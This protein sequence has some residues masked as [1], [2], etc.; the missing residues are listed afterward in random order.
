MGYS[1]HKDIISLEQR[2]NLKKN[3]KNFGLKAI[4][5]I[6]QFGWL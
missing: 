3:E 5:E 1:K 4:K 2:N 6:H